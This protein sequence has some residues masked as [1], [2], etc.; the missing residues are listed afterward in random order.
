MFRTVD[1]VRQDRRL[2][3]LLQDMENPTG[4]GMAREGL[5]PMMFTECQE[6]VV[7]RLLEVTAA[8]FRLYI[9]AADTIRVLDLET[10]GRG[11]QSLLEDFGGE[12]L[13]DTA[14]ENDLHPYELPR[15]SAPR[16]LD[17][18]ETLVDVP[19]PQRKV[20]ILSSKAITEEER[21]PLPNALW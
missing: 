12:H 8:C 7:R 14:E 11:A 18:S 15:E 17:V 6:H 1:G 19:F 13:G 20:E 2:T 21:T 9:A 4:V 3:E 10:Q 16:L 5:G